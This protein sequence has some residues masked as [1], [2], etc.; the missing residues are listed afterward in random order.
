MKNVGPIEQEV[1]NPEEGQCVM[2]LKSHKE[3]SMAGTEC[4]R[5]RIPREG[6]GEVRVEESFMTL[7]AIA[8]PLDLIMIEKG[9]LW[10]AL[11][12]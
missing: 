12:R 8:R 11:I 3:V 4:V 9:C 5:Q 6:G 10:R 2:G 7:Q 1:K